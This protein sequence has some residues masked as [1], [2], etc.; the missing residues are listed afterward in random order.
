MVVRKDDSELLFGIKHELDELLVFEVW[1]LG[2]AHGSGEGAGF[3]GPLLSG[4][5][6]DG[7]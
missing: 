6:E 7:K 1:R 4:L 5:R 3:V 2:E